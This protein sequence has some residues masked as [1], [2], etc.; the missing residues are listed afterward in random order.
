MGNQRRCMLN[1]RCEHE[2]SVSFY[3]FLI[4]II[5]QTLR[6]CVR[7]TNATD[8]QLCKL[9]TEKIVS[10]IPFLLLFLDVYQFKKVCWD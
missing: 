5:N 3:T 9:G 6:F 7:P 8:P 4:P 1:R 2:D 10:N